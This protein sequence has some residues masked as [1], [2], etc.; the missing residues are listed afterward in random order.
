MAFAL[1]APIVYPFDMPRHVLYVPENPGDTPRTPAPAYVV[2][3]TFIEVDVDQSEQADIDNSKP[4][5]RRRRGSSFFRSSSE[6]LTVARAAKENCG[7]PIHSDVASTEDWGSDSE[8]TGVNSH[9]AEEDSSRSPSP[10]SRL[11]S[12]PFQSKVLPPKHLLDN[13]PDMMN[14]VGS[15][16]GGALPRGIQPP[17][18][19]FQ[20]TPESA[21]AAAMRAGFNAGMMA[22]AMRAGFN[23]G[24]HASGVPS[25]GSASGVASPSG[26]ATPPRQAP[27]SVWVNQLQQVAHHQPIVGVHQ[28]TDHKSCHLIWCD[29]RAFK[30]T[31]ASMKE[32]LQNCTQLTVKTHRTAENCLRLLRKKRNAQGRPPCVFLVSWANSR[33]LLAFLSEEP[34]MV[35][36]VVVL[37]D[38]RGG[39]RHDAADAL[40]RQYPFVESIATS[41]PEAVQAVREA[42]ASI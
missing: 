12:S 40:I 41:W 7:A 1:P 26:I 29:H 35:A 15:N 2:R 20:Q 24:V 39:R 3:N 19:N 34:Q 28:Q 16:F 11:Q 18:G 14:I 27:P 6:P 33:E 37:C 4:A 17:P 32:E 38:A 22:A 42:V 9:I 23:A 36:K 21:L 25:S 5:Y 30:D 13:G 31:S 8:Q 10:S